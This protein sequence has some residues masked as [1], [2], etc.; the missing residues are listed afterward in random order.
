MKYL[1]HS[2]LTFSAPSRAILYDE[3]E[4]LVGEGHDVTVI[5][6]GK[7]LDMCFTNMD[8]NKKNCTFCTANYLFYDRINISSK[9]KMISLKDY[10]TE[11]ILS[12]S[13]S[14]KFPYNDINDIKKIKYKNVSIGLACLSSYVSFTRN[15]YPLIDEHFITY[16]DNLLRNSALQCDLIE[17]VIDK[18]KPDCIYGYN[19]R[20]L[21]SRPVWEIAKNNAIPFGLLEAQYTFSFCNKI[22]FNNDTP[23]SIPSID[24]N[25]IQKLWDTSDIELDEKKILGSE[26]YER[27]R[28]ALPAGD[29]IYTKNQKIGLIPDGWDSSKKNIV[30]FTSSEDEFVAIGEEF[31]KFSIFPSQIAGIQELVDRF[32]NDPQIQFYLRIHPNLLNVEYSYHKKLY[33]LAKYSNLK[34]IEPQSVISSYSLIDN[35]DI[36]VVFGSTIGVEAAYWG[37]P[38]I[39]LSGAMYYYLDCCYIPASKNELFDLIN[40][41]LTP[42]DKLGVYKFGLTYHDSIGQT[43]DLVDCNWKTYSL[44]FFGYTKKITLNNWEKLFG[45]HILFF[46]AR[47]VSY[48][49][50]KIYCAMKKMG[51]R[52]KVPTKETD[53]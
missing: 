11:E 43:C 32:I 40:S 9:I 33:E 26:F 42:K 49:P 6:C 27:R 52:Y 28:K 44:K 30:I 17:S 3:A 22:L 37:K 51:P 4:K 38:T 14:T 25:F 12:E 19:G 41:H 47:T 13:R 16:F 46:I 5:F 21:D 50:V 53:F 1:L 31:E 10:L 39:L 24:K 2:S 18:L 36:V 20:F 29:K 15:L 48:I 23:H 35:S 45:S 8:G 7:S 34:I